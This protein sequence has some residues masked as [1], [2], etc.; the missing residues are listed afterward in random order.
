MFYRFR[1]I[2]PFIITNHCV[3]HR[4]ALCAQKASEQIPLVTKFMGT[5]NT[6]A[7]ALK[8]SPKLCRALESSASLHEEHK[9][10]VKQV[11]FTR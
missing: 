6:Y 9:K 11:F 2:L 1:G 8:Y 4:L 5:L 7:K 3:A 10:K